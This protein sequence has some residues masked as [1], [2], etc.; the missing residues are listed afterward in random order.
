M[1]YIPKIVWNDFGASPW[2]EYIP[3]IVFVAWM[4]LSRAMH[5]AIAE[6]RFWCI[7]MDGVAENC[8]SAIAPALP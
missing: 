5:G 3:K 1:E 8:S 6:E 2:M 4:S 7:S